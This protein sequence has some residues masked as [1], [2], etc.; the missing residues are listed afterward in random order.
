MKFRMVHNNF[1]VLDLE[2]SLKFYADAFDMLVKAE[3]LYKKAGD[4]KGAAVCRQEIMSLEQRIR[5]VIESTDP[6][7]A[8]LSGAPLPLFVGPATKVTPPLT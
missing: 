6:L 7:P 3:E 8:P 5:E 4:K 2:K 1:N